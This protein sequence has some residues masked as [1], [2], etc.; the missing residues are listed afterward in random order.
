MG[1]RRRPTSKCNLGASWTKINASQRKPMKAK[2][3]GFIFIYFSESGLFN[4]LRPIQTEK[5]FS[6][7]TRPS[8]VRKS[9]FAC[10]CFGPSPG[11]RG[12]SADQNEQ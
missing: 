6:I 5:S 8:V 4:G 12:M 3:L 2:R 10:R 7:P 1:N 9:T 11:E